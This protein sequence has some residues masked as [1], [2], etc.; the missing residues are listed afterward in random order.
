MGWEFKASHPWILV[1]MI[2]Y[3]AENENGFPSHATYKVISELE[4]EIETQLPA[5]QGYIF[6][7][8]ETIDGLR[9]TFIAC[10]EFRNATEEVSKLQKEYEQKLIFDY[11]F[12]KDKYWQ[13]FERYQID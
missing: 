2:R 5:E 3:Q 12:Y 11:E 10:R 9:E 13:S 6:L 8:S 1:V 4:D 7:G